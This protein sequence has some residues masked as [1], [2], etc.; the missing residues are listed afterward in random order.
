MADSLL[1]RPGADLAFAVRGEG[2]LVGY[3]HGLFFSRAAEDAA[4]L[5]DLAPLLAERRLL[6]YDARGH[7]RSG[8]EPDPSR[9]TWDSLADDL[10]AM[11]DEVRGGE[12]V[13]WIGQ[14]MGTGSLL[15]AAVRSPDRFRRLVLEIPPTTG[16]T[17]AGARQMY[18]DGADF[19]ERQG[20]E[21]WLRGM[22]QFGVPEILA[23][24]PTYRYVA[25]VRAETLPSVLRGAALTDLP[26]AEALAALPHPA[27]ILAWESDPVH[28]VST[29]E[30]LVKTL[31]DARLHV[32]SDSADVRTWPARVAEFLRS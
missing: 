5:V 16:E 22:Q 23:D 13:D 18:R 26:P 30:F 3:S 14:S 12:P 7:G 15:H 31:P 1:S 20:R 10:I 19:V 11:A 6:R 24:V 27:L 28:P 4:D 21:A 2:P 29:A 32:S 25:D 17:R 9:Y 8:G